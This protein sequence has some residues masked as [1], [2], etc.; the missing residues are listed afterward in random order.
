MRH[1]VTCAVFLAACFN[2]VTATQQDSLADAYTLQSVDLE[3]LPALADG[4]TG[5]RWVLS[6]SL[7]LRPDGY[8]VLSERDS[9]WNGHTFSREDDIEGGTWMADGSMLT[10]SDT[11]TAMIDTYGA[12]A[13][14]YFGSIRPDVMLLTVPTDDGAKTHVYRYAR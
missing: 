7:L 5:S 11:A 2:G 14:T 4:S 12:A 1:F 3:S 10:L 13:P 8:Y 6:G 9:I